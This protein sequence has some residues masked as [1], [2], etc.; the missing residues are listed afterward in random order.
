[1]MARL[2]TIAEASNYLWSSDSRGLRSRT[3]DFLKLNDVP[4]L[5]DGKQYFV[6]LAD[7][8]R[9]AGEDDRGDA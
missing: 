8:R 6:R 4:L 7:L 5:K 3:R 1:M 2:L 9:L